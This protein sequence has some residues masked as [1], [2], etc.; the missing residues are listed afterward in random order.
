M[1]KNSS[2]AGT[3]AEKLWSLHEME[4]TGGEPDV[5]GRDKKTGESIFM[6]VQTRVLKLTRSIATTAE[7]G[8]KSTNR[9]IALWMWQRSWALSFARRN[10][11]ETHRNWEISMQNVE[12]VKTPS[13]IEIRARA[14]FVIA[15]MSMFY[16]VSQRCGSYYA[17]GVPW[18]AKV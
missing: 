17:V 18:L 7:L 9:Q 1:G 12:L 4:R 13:D 15:A 10:N 5:V 16:S 14:L 2:Q 6:I 11:I 3:N 8:R